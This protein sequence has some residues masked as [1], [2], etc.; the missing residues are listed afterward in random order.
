M[1]SM[2]IFSI[3]ICINATL[4]AMKQNNQLALPNWRGMHNQLCTDYK[5]ILKNKL[6]EYKNDFSITPCNMDELVKVGQIITKVDKKV[7]LDGYIYM[8]KDNYERHNYFMNIAVEKDDLSTINW[9]C[10]NNPPFFRFYNKNKENPLDQCIKKLL[11]SATNKP[12]NKITQQIFDSMLT[13][14]AEQYLPADSGYDTYKE[15]CLI[16][17]IALQLRYTKFGRKF[18][19]NSNALTKLLPKPKSKP[20]SLQLALK[21]KREALSSYYREAIDKLDGRTFTHV[22]ASQQNPDALCE[23]IEKKRA[24]FAEDAY[25]HTALDYALLTLRHH[26]QNETSPEA[27]Q[28]ASCCVYILLN[29]AKSLALENA[30]V[31]Y[32]HELYASDI[33]D[34]GP[35]C[36][37]HTFSKA[38]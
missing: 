20:L 10:A 16:D 2:Y 13:C 24:S 15:K 35:C 21:Y 22:F 26:T 32:L 29:H 31:T 4:H 27:I 1:K 34:F 11:P 7:L 3:L 25:N 6:E 14:M 28:K 36:D 38:V 19:V 33:S 18:I 17:I 12:S 37:K 30:Q 23:L 9:L 5:N 8:T